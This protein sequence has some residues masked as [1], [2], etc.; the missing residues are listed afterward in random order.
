MAR[1]GSSRNLI[2][3][4]E[5]AMFENNPRKDS[6]VIIDLDMLGDKNELLYTDPEIEF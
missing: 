1:N 4:M 2:S 3:D 6:E 5:E